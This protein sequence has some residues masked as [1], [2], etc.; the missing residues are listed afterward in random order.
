[1]ESSDAFRFS[2]IL[3][4]SRNIDLKKWAV[5]ACDQYTSEP[6]YWEDVERFVGDAPST[7]HM[8]LPEVYLG[9]PVEAERVAQSREAMEHYVN[10][11][12]LEETAPGGI[13]VKRRFSDG[14]ERKGLMLELDL[15]RYDFSKGSRSLIRPTEQTI[16]ERIPPRIKMRELASLELPHIMVLV[17]DPQDSLFEALEESTQAREPSYATE[18][19]KGGGDLRGYALVE[20]DRLER[21]AAALRNLQAQ[22]A[23][24][25]GDTMLFAV[26]DGNHSLA[27]AKT[28]WE[29][30]KRSGSPGPDH[31]ARYALVEVV[32]LHDPGLRFEP[33][34]RAVFDPPEGML[35]ELLEKLG[36]EHNEVEGAAERLSESMADSEG[37]ASLIVCDSEREILV[38]GIDLGNEIIAARVQGILDEMMV[39][40]PHSAID[41][42]HGADAAQKLAR[43][44]GA[45]S[46]L[47]PA[48]ARRQLFPYVIERGVLPRKAF[49]L[50]EAEEKRY[51]FEA[52][53]IIE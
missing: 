31:P 41:F 13:F 40:S 15:E 2:R 29:N 25:R 24:A 47:L 8:I 12:I 19:M 35:E 7:L 51:Y 21:I 17:D 23:T 33:I 5:I 32:N 48:I 26:G 37:G 38:K 42:I 50:G 44:R 46:V 28:H 43:E 45:L 49:S 52:R 34:H 10:D 27:T 4:P 36:G 30:L 3:L 1:M 39:K 9:S 20:E 22:S 16:V 6:E 53:R 14:V 18:L 11:G